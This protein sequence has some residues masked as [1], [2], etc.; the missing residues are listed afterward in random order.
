MTKYCMIRTMT[1]MVTAMAGVLFQAGEA[2]KLAGIT[3]NQLREWTG[4]RAIISPDV[5][6]RG[7]GKHALFSPATVLVLRMI[8][9][10]RTRFLMEVGPLSSMAEDL[11]AHLAEIPFMALYGRAVSIKSP[12]EYDIINLS[13]AKVSASAVVIP[14]EGH[15]VAISETCGFRDQLTQFQLF[16]VM[17]A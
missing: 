15:L 7:R 2:A 16:P 12:D 17:S 4:R 5:P 3:A 10:L 11:R 6:G 14:F 8:A 9:E 13:H 1:V